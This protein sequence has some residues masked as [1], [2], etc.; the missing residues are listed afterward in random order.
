MPIAVNPGVP[1]DYVLKCDRE[2]EPEQKTVFQL[3]PL[4]PSESAQLEDNLARVYASDET[5]TVNTGTHTLKQLQMGLIGWKNFRN[6]EGEEIPFPERKDAR[7]KTAHL[8]YLA[9]EWRQEIANAIDEGNTV[10][11]TDLKNSD[12]QLV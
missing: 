7:L 12:S 4:T 10:T 5:L 2:L 1:F 11:E 3:K 8:A 9:P 6:A